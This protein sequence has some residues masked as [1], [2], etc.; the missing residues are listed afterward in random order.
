MTTKLMTAAVA[1]LA[2]STLLTPSAEARG[3]RFGLGVGLPLGVLLATPSHAQDPYRLERRQAELDAEELA[4]RR[5]R[6]RRMELAKARAKAEKLAAEKALADKVATIETTPPAPAAKVAAA[7]QL[8]VVATAST[9]L[10]VNPDAAKS[11]ALQTTPVAPRASTP[12][13]STAGEA[14][15]TGEMCQK[16]LPSVGVMMAVP[17]AE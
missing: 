15:R 3:L 10:A 12:A 17:C 7:S 14:A 13:K 9:G 2:A 11:Y 4:M 8:P 6:A 16:F 5:E 1:L